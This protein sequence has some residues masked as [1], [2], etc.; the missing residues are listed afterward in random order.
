MQKRIVRFASFKSNAAIFSFLLLLSFPSFAQGNDLAPVP[1]EL[2]Q[3][4]RREV[5]KFFVGGFT[6]NGLSWFGAGYQYSS[7]IALSF[8]WQEQ[9]VIQRFDLDATAVQADLSGVLTLTNSEKI[10][11]QLALQLEWFPFSGPYYFAAGGGLENY[12]EKQR[13]TEAYVPSGNYKDYSWDFSQQKLFL[14]AG[15]GFRYIFPSGFFIHVGGNL[16]LYPNRPTHENRGAYHT[17]YNWDYRQ[18]QK[19]W[20]EPSKEAKSHQ[21]LYG[22]QLQI[23]FGIAI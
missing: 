17:N 1:G 5:R 13:K 23:L 16:L 10:Q 18:F 6:A 8:Q 9:R 15:A 4:K 11:R 3:A 2:E 22:A 14:S 20:D 21:N 19:D 12:S 7:K